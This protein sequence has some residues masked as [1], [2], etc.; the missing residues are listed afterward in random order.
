MAERF[1]FLPSLGF[2]IAVVILLL[3]LLNAQNL[4]QLKLNSKARAVFILLIILF[5][6]RTIARNP[7]WKN[8]K[9]LFTADV[10]NSP[11]SARLNFGFGNLFRDSA[12]HTSD[13]KLKTEAAAIA[14]QA[15]S[16]A[17]A[18]DSAYP[19]PCYNMGVTY[20]STGDTAN[21][22]RMYLKT[23]ELK[24]EYALAAYNLGAIFF[25]Q[26]KYESSLKYFKTAHEIQPE[27][28]NAIFNTGVCYHL[29]NDFKN[30]IVYYNQALLINST[31]VSLLRNLSI[32][33][34]N[35]GDTA[36]ANYYNSLAEQQ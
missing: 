24:P 33:Y 9:T 11:N 16:H 30:A 29:M 8:N 31:D 13:M 26:K 28:Y 21:A 7:D 2:C 12:M 5:A 20:Y 4:D 1:L 22:V 18:I 3:K 32:S 35:L 19:D 23:L 27:N 25:N 34:A 10:K 36:K 14:I 6:G 17:L 15:Y